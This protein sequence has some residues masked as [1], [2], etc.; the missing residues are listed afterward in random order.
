[1]GR[2]LQIIG[3][4]TLFTFFWYLISFIVLVL[5]DPVRAQGAPQCDTREAVVTLLA[6]RYGEQPMA[7]GV[8]GGAA[9]MEVYANE[10]TGTWTITMTLPEGLMCLM[11]S[12]T[13]YAAMRGQL[14][15]NL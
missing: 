3:G 9:V 15:A 14:P 4:A 13:D 10:S 6:D 1:M 8:A 11:A 2:L 5:P 7:M 12:G